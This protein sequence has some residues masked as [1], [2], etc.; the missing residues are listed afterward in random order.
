MYKIAKFAVFVIAAGLVLGITS[1]STPVAAD[2]DGECRESEAGFERADCEIHE[3]TGSTAQ[4]PSKQDLAF[5]TGT[6]QGGHT[7]DA[8]ESLGGC[9]ILGDPGNSD[10]NR[11]DNNDDDD[12]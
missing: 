7:S 6:C 2:K 1:V 8:L 3:N 5:H 12:E 9:D 11:Q 4:D 10:E